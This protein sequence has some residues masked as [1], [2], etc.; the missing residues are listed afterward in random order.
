MLKKTPPTDAKLNGDKKN[1]DFGDS[2]SIAVVQWQL[3]W[4]VCYRM[5][6]GTVDFI[7]VVELQYLAVNRANSDS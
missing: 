1:S 3:K 2:I 6:Q 4:S 5:F 7:P